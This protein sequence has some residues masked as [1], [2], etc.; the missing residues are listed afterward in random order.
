MPSTQYSFTAG[1]ELIDFELSEAQIVVKRNLKPSEF[2]TADLAQFYVASNGKK[3]ELILVFK[4]QGKMRKV[5]RLPSGAGQP[6]LRSIVERLTELRPDASLMELR[7]PAALREL[8]IA[9]TWFHKSLLLALIPFVVFT[10]MK[11]SEVLVALDFG[12][13]SVSAKEIRSAESGNVTITDARVLTTHIVETKK[14]RR[15]SRFY[16]PVVPAGWSGNE[17]VEAVLFAYSRKSLIALENAD[18]ID[19]LIRD[20]SQKELSYQGAQMLGE[21]LPVDPSNLMTLEVPPPSRAELLQYALTLP[22]IALLL[23]IGLGFVLYRRWS[24]FDL[25]KLF[26]AK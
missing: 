4:P 3:A 20:G 15:G 16:A 8:K 13:V 6:G 22:I 11:F 17:K 18:S 24:A 12:K 14:R 26:P 10:G 19:A 5:L 2:S 1:K 9:N 23:G 21:T 7:L 25:A